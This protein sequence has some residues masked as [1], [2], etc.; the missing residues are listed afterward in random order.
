MKYR[1]SSLLIGWIIGLLSSTLV[2]RRLQRLILRYAPEHFRHQIEEK[3]LE[4]IRTVRRFSSD[5]KSS[6]PNSIHRSENSSKFFPINDSLFN[7]WIR[8][9]NS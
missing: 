9:R 5:L 6:T 7:N 2:R 4:M 8:Y 3:R 1:L